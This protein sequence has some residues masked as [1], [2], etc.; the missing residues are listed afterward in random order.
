M[1]EKGTNSKEDTNNMNTKDEANS[2]IEKDK[3]SKTGKKSKTRMYIVLLFILLVVVVG[4]VIYRGEYLEILE[5]GEE[6][7]ELTLLFYSL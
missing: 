2:N 3:T 6:L 1:N 4:Y 5:I 7:L